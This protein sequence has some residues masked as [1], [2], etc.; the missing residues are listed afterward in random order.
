MMMYSKVNQ[1]VNHNLTMCCRAI[2]MCHRFV[3]SF[4]LYYFF[5][6]KNGRYFII[7]KEI[8]KM[9]SICVFQATQIQLFFA[10][11]FANLA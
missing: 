5:F 8:Y 10:H 1:L 3:G 4:I 2:L 9:S 6:F 7:S 11:S